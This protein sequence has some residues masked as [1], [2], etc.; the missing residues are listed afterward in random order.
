MG[1]VWIYL[2]EGLL[3]SVGRGVMS[4]GQFLGR[5]HN[6]GWDLMSIRHRTWCVP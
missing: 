4:L 2:A 5:I 6:A 1:W 3:G